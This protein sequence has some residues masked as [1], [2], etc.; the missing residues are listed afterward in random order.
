MNSE[1]NLQKAAADSTS[2]DA[3]LGMSSAKKHETLAPEY[4]APEAAQTAAVQSYRLRPVDLKVRTG[5]GEL[6]AQHNVIED[7]TRPNILHKELLDRAV[8]G[9]I[10]GVHYGH[11]KS[12]PACLI[13][14]HFKFVFNRDLL[15]FT[16]AKIVFQF[17]KSAE[18]A[19]TVN[20]TAK[21]VVR[22]YSPKQIY[23]YVGIEHV[24]FEYGVQMQC[25]VSAGPFK[26]GPTPYITK[27]SAYDKEH[28]LEIIGQ[29]YRKRN[30][31]EPL[32]VRWT[33]TER[34]KA[35]K[36]IPRD[37]NVGIVVEHDGNFKAKVEVEVETPLAT[38]FGW[39]WPKDDPLLFYPPMGI[40]DGPSNLA[41][42]TMTDAEWSRLVPYLGEGTVSER[43][44]VGDVPG[45]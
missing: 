17:D 43:S 9:A 38:L 32:E 30:S 8:E 20:G 26:V 23:G 13:L 27:H 3:M 35:G 21:P 22:S 5:L 6:G 33:A 12:K 25:S 44:S 1:A 16:K 7:Q 41:F 15:R 45:S 2:S 37:L 18:T 29:D 10:I 24:D 4:T 40:G 31:P 36:G 39:P 14:V 11:Y 34:G 28:Q 19:G 42:D